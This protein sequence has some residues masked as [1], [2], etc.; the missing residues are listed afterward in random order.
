MENKFVT[1]GL[2][3]YHCEEGVEKN[4]VQNNKKWKNAQK[5]QTHWVKET[6]FY[7]LT[8]ETVGGEVAF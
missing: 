5:K 1:N 6:L 7:F 3:K 4:M 8:K 2:K